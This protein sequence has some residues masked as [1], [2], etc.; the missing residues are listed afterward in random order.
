MCR[1]AV[2]DMAGM[3][4][5]PVLPAAAAVAA[6]QHINQAE[7]AGDA[8]FDFQFNMDLVDPSLVLREMDDVDALP[9]RSQAERAR[10]VSLGGVS[11]VSP[12]LPRASMG[13]AASVASSLHM[14]AHD[15][16]PIDFDDMG[17]GLPMEVARKDAHVHDDAFPDY[18]MPDY[19]MPLPLPPS[20]K[21]SDALAMTPA[22][23]RGSG[24]GAAVAPGSVDP[25]RIS[26]GGL[27]MGD[28]ELP[29]MPEMDD[30]A[31]LAVGAAGVA[32]A[33]APPPAKLAKKKDVEAEQKKRARVVKHAPLPFDAATELS[34]E[35]IKAQ[36]ADRSA[37]FYAK[38]SDGPMVRF[39]HFFKFSYL[40]IH[41]SDSNDKRRTMFFQTVL[42]THMFSF[43]VLCS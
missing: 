42:V 41:V 11:D 38:V 30:A 28:M 39:G 5:D 43:L 16:P 12:A 19:D 4:R 25:H 24:V 37:L 17:L 40:G 27:S 14:H 3:L 36:L 23:A 1:D 6:S 33:A 15:L 18:D 29:E 34:N 7:W 13:K 2:V 26:L 8:L 9:M 32:A 20:A 21:K 31:L 10:A 35:E 22:S